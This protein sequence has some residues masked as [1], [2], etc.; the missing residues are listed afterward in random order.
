MKIV[1]NRCFGGFGISRKAQERIAQLLGRE[2]HWF[3]HGY[4]HQGEPK[5][6]PDNNNSDKK[7]RLRSAFDCANFDTIYF[8]T[9]YKDSCFSNAVWKTHEI[10]AFRDDLCG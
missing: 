2:C 8:D 7:F 3:I 9:I 1:I 6:I 10:P 5:L 4:S